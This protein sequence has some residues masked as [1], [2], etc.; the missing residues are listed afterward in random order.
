[1]QTAVNAVNKTGARLGGPIV[2]ALSWYWASNAPRPKGWAMAIVWCVPPLA[3]PIAMAGLKALN[4]KP[5][6]S[7][8]E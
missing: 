4:A 8:A 2:V 3:F 5:T 6:V 7:R 1:M